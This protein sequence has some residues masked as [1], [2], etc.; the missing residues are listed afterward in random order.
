MRPRLAIYAI[1]WLTIILQASCTT[2]IDFHINQG[3]KQTAINCLY[4]KGGYIDIYA[5]YSVPLQNKYTINPNLK[6]ECYEENNLLGEA[7]LTNK[8]YYRCNKS[9]S[10][11]CN[12]LITDTATHKTYELLLQNLNEVYIQSALSFPD[13]KI[14]NENCALE[15][16]KYEI[17]FEDNPDEDNYYELVFPNRGGIKISHPVFS[18][19][20]DSHARILFSDKL[21]D[22][23]PLTLTLY[24]SYLDKGKLRNVDKSYFEYFKSLEAHLDAQNILSAGDGGL[25]LFFQPLPTELYSN[26]T[27]GLGVFASYSETEYRFQIVK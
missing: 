15:L 4:N 20:C 1:I 13:K 14:Y 21:F 2:E 10:S 5:S 6:I 11:E 24:S 16:L 25:D 9:F 22:G 23:E 17:T 27:G 8:D 3:E 19:E 12:I 18:I 7:T 26:V